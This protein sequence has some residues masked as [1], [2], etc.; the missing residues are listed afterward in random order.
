MMIQLVLGTALALTT[1]ALPPA[2]TAKDEFVFNNRGEPESIDPQF[3]TGVPD[4][5]IIVQLFE[6]L[7]AK[8]SDWSTLRPGAAESYTISKDLKT[9]TFK[10][11]PNLKWSDGSPLTAK[12]FEY[13]WLRA[14]R[15]ETLSSYGYWF[16]DNIVGG[17]EYAAKPTAET[18]AKVGLKA[19][20]DRTFVVTLVKPLAYFIYF[21]AESLSFPIKK[22]VF[23]KHGDKWTR[24]E[25]IVSNGPYRMVEW[26]VQDRI[27]M[28]KNPHYYDAASVALKKI[29]ALPIE[30]RQ[31]GVNMF[32]QGKL[33]WTGQNG[34]PNSL[35]PSFKSDPH[36]R[37]FPGFVTYFYRLNVTRPPLNDKRVRQAL[38]LA[39]DRKQLVEKVTRGGEVATSSFVPLNTGS[40]V[41]A[42]GLASSDYKKDVEK[43]RKL[44]AEAGFPGGKGMRQLMIQYNTDENHKKIALAMQQMWKKELGVESQPY[45]QEWKVYLKNQ[46]ALDYDVSRSGWSGDYPDPSTFLELFTTTSENNQTGWKSPKYDELFLGANG[47]AAGAERNKKMAEAEAW[48][49]D[50][51]PIIPF[52][53][54]TNF[55]LLRPEVVGFVENPVDRPFIRYFS[56]K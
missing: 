52:Y 56:K 46:K 48:L 39:I 51:A 3:A 34:M 13:T 30:D 47:M 25:N 27:V 1:G 10:L 12:D 33:D 15:P 50:E 4:N 35:V 19:T 24:P 49:L 9:Y 21:T 5:D 20:D 32:Q 16:I 41:P 23:E 29:V 14:M 22:S 37:Q 55:G 26:K 38:A 6:G 31:T 42:P 7:M 44:L 53:Y 2:Q 43:A 8:N 36:F 18:A 45:N 54:Y 40:Y 11:R 17:K 28:E